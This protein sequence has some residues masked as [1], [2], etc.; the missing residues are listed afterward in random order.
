MALWVDDLWLVVDH[1]KDDE[2]VAVF[3]REKDAVTRA[4]VF[5]YHEHGEKPRFEVLHL[6]V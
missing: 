2:V 6:E 1:A 5:G 3:L 4:T